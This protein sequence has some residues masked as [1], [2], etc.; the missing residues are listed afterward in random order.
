L[1]TDSELEI[2]QKEWREQT[3]PLPELKKKIKRQ[4]LRTVGAIAATGVCLVVSTTTALRTH[5]SFM[6]GLASGIWFASIL[7]GSYGWWVRRGAWKPTA[8]TTRAYLELTY[9][10]AVARARIL[11][12]AFYFL[13][14]AALLYAGFV[15]WDWHAIRGKGLMLLVLAGMVVELFVFRHL[16]RRKKKEIEQTRKLAEQAN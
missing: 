12:F 6:V 13:L 5:G 2:W 11:R 14:I 15:I 10:R 16:A 3:E 9:K 8:Q 1:T 7:M 4:N